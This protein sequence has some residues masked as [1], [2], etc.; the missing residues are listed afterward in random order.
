MHFTVGTWP[1]WV[2]RTAVLVALFVAGD[3]VRRTDH[4]RLIPQ[5]EA[6][7]FVEQSTPV[8]F[9]GRPIGMAIY[10]QLVPKCLTDANV[11]ECRGF[12]T[13]AQVFREQWDISESEV[14]PLQWS[15]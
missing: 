7:Q 9:S 11:E 4:V 1:E 3:Y 10:F 6:K 5:F 15:R 13:A 8:L 2:N 14:L 12:L